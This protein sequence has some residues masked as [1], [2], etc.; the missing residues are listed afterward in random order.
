P[1]YEDEAIAL[2]PVVEY[3]KDAS[4]VLGASD[5]DCHCGKILLLV[6]RPRFL[7]KLNITIHYKFINFQVKGQKLLQN[8]DRPVTIAPAE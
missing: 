5:C 3:I 8:R 7:I 2:E 1:T 6:K 4:F